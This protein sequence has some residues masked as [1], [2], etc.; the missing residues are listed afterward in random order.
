MVFI[1]ILSPKQNI[2]IISI[3]TI[4]FKKYYLVFFFKLKIYSIL[5]SCT[6]FFFLISH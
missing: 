2:K 6:F 5:K 1:K 4:E 3:N